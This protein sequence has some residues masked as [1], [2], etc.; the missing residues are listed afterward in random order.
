MP[1][2]YGLILDQA[3]GAVKLAVYSDDDFLALRSRCERPPGQAQADQNQKNKQSDIRFL[4]ILN[5]KY[6]YYEVH[7][8]KISY[9]IIDHFY[10]NNAYYITDRLCGKD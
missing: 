9:T 8:K 2:F 3:V 10:G 1:D 7:M 5:M 4:M 6:S